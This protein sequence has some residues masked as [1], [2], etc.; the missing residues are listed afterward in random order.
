MVQLCHLRCTPAALARDN[1]ELL[2]VA[3]AGAHDK[4]LNDA[5]FL[6]RGGQFFQLFWRKAA[7]RLVRVWIHAFDRHVHIGTALC[8]IFGFLGL[9]RRYIG[10]KRR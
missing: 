4:R 8:A 1:L 3:R 5:L 9:R 2:G 7:P 6:D 10:H